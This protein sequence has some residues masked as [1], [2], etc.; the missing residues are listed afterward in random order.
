[1]TEEGD[2][3]AAPS[4]PSARTAT[5]ESFRLRRDAVILTGDDGT[6]VLRHT[7]FELPLGPLGVGR[8]ALI[9]R[10]GDHWVSEVE[11][12]RLVTGLE[13]ENRVLAAQVLL[14]RL[15]AH[16]WLERRLQVGTRILIDVLPRGLGAGSVP[17]TRRHARAARYQLSRFAARRTRDGRLMASPPV[18]SLTVGCV[19][20]RLGHVLAE[21]AAG[22]C[23]RVG[24]AAQLGVDETAA[25]RVLDELLTARILVTGAQY[26]EEQN[27]APLAY[28]SAD[29]LTVHDRSRPGGHVA[30]VGGTYPFRDRFPAPPL[31]PEPAGILSVPL[32]VP[33][34]DLVAKTDPSLTRVIQ[35][36]H[37]IRDHDDANPLTIDQLGE[38]LYRVQHTRSRGV[39]AG[40]EVG[41][42]PY[43]GGGSLCELE[44]YAMVT[45]C[46]GLPPGLY[47]YESFDHRLELLTEQGGVDNQV[48]R[49]ARA[50]AAINTL[51][52][53][54]L[55]VT[56]RIQRL[57]WKYEGL[58][59]AMILKNAGVLTELMYLV[60]TAMG[61]APCALG[62]GHA[63]G[64][65]ALS[66]LDPLVEPSV[67]D[68]ILGSRLDAPSD[69]SRMRAA[70]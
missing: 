61:L 4:G 28:W 41:E 58:S 42:R 68:F 22:T 5:H 11:L 69:S 27:A 18:S 50:A 67:A 6:Q 19:D 33:N 34:L 24:V 49:Y 9:L 26:E 64:F 70:G 39:S 56:A 31:R 15:A 10:L 14:R 37:S 3:T 20:T 66:G 32:E 59:Y 12:H 17:E 57:M 51:P 21:A 48:L 2:M 1:M 43:P 65:A 52:Q 38:F 62:A 44:I 25:G 13:G 30:P 54:L 35:D 63:A 60:A 53:V 40:Q 8:Q 16:S 36:R 7:R 23:D 45:R 46:D 47:H 55:V 29:E